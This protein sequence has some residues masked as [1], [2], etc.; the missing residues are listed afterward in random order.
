MVIENRPMGKSAGGILFLRGF[1]YLGAKA[2]T[3]NQWPW[4]VTIPGHA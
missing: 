2:G 1:R 4:R 3:R